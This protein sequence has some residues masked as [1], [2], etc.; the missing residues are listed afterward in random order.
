MTTVEKLIEVIQDYHRARAVYVV[1]EV[2]AC[3]GERR[4]LWCCG[5]TESVLEKSR[6]LLEFEFIDAKSLQE[7]ELNKTVESD[8]YGNVYLKITKCQVTE[9]K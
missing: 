6:E 2:D 8:E 5:S 3:E 4:G 7:L 1:E 9:I